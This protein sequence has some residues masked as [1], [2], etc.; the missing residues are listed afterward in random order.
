[1]LYVC[2]VDESAIV[3][4]VGNEYTK[5]VQALAQQEGAPVIY[6]CGKTEEEL[7]A[8]DKEERMEYLSSLQLKKSGLE[9]MILASYELLG[10]LTFF[11]AGEEEVRAWTIANGC[12]AAQAAGEIHTDIEQ[13][14]ICGEVLAYDDFIRYGSLLSARKNGKMRLEGKD[15]LVQD[16]DIVHFRFNKTVKQGRAV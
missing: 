8:L 7:I 12:F 9:R 13:G 4:Q 3:N 6:I 10:L 15:Y 14:F 2:N 16:G 5:K 11:T 1:M